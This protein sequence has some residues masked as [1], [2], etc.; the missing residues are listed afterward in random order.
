MTSKVETINQDELV[1][2]TIWTHE[3]ID[4]AIDASYYFDNEMKLTTEDK[5]NIMHEIEKQYDSC[6]GMTWEI[7][8]QIIAS[9]VEKKQPELLCEV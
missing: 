6:F 1:F 9:Y 4:S 7:L 5:N 2:I 8:E 3:D